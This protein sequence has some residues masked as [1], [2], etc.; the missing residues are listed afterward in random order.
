MMCFL[1]RF[2]SAKELNTHRNQWLRCLSYSERY[3][4]WELAQSS[5]DA[6]GAKRKV[7]DGFDLS[8]CEKL[9]RAKALVHEL[10]EAKKAGEGVVIFSQ[11]TFLSEWALLV[12]LPSSIMLTT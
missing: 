1:N 8:E 11:Q 9:C 5:K 4:Q 7:W 12:I 6:A 2:D 10:R 3:I